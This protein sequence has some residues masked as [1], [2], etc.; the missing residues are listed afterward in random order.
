MA[1]QVLHT[2]ATNILLCRDGIGLIVVTCQHRHR[3]GTNISSSVKAVRYITCFVST[4]V[5]GLTWCRY[6]VGVVSAS[7]E[8][9]LRV[10]AMLLRLSMFGIVV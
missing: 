2:Q 7:M 4:N 10:T 5:V 6:C 3:P 1:Q 9:P 8:R